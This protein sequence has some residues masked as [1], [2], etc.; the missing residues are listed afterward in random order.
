M[1]VVI[2][3]S[4][5]QLGSDLVEEFTAYGDEVYPLTHADLNVEDFNSVHTALSTLKPDC[6]VNPTAFHVV[7]QCESDPLKAF[8]INALG[9]LHIAKTSEE[10][11]ALNVYYSTD[12]VFDGAQHHPYIETDAPN[13]LNIYASTKLLGEYYTLNYCQKGFAVR[14]SGL[15]GKV[16]CRAKGGNFIT[17]MIKAAKEKSEVKVVQDEIL[18]PTPTREIARRTIY[19]I[20]SGAFGLFH[21]TC[22]GECSWYEF[23]KVIFSMLKIQTP[24]LPCSVK[25]FPSIVRRPFYSVLENKKANELQLQKMPYWKEALETFLHDNYGA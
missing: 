3:G 16:P 21:L 14:V 22:E 4:N 19:V 24:L 18:T 5:G 15:Y 13:P 7:H 25:D 20:Q 9:A 8:Q 10:L 17:T 11:G 12:Y 23:A 1:R 6:V 2:L